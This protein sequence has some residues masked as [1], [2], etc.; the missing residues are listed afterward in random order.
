MT[1]FP[2]AQSAANSQSRMFR[3]D[4]FDRWLNWFARVFLLALLIAGAFVMALPFVWMVL[5]SLKHSYEIYRVPITWLPDNLLN[6]DSY[7]EIF[8]RQPFLRFMLNSLV[9][10]L[11][12]T[13]ASLLFSSMAGF[14]FAKY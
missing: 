6:L 5:T 14:A 12:T 11:G 1:T 8:E 7:R 9:V 13:L 2:I 4:Q 10:S 3:R